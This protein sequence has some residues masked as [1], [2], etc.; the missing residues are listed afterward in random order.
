MGTVSSYKTKREKVNL[1]ML[2]IV[3]TKLNFI[4]SIKMAANNGS[5]VIVKKDMQQWTIPL[6]NKLLN[7]ENQLAQLEHPKF[8][9][10]VT[11]GCEIL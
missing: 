7:S 11:F 9:T 1:S 6:F 8:H 3:M 4:K 2:L 5:D 10:I